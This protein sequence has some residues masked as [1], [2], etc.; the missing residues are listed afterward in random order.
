M[1]LAQ[2][3]WPLRKWDSRRQAYRA[4]LG[5]SWGYHTAKDLDLLESIHLKFLPSHSLKLQP[6]EKLWLLTKEGV[7]NE[8]FESLDELEDTLV[9]RCI[10]LV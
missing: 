1:E 3:G 8:L 6:A 7:T 5:P 10:E 4:R 9:E 2:D